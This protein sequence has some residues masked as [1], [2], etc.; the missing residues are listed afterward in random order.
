MRSSPSIKILFSYSTT[1]LTPIAN[2]SGPPSPSGYGPT[3]LEISTAVAQ[4]YRFYYSY[5][6]PFSSGPT[7]IAATRPANAPTVIIN[8]QRRFI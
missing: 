1:A 8:T 2:P 3:F 6:V 5:R 7:G 4:F